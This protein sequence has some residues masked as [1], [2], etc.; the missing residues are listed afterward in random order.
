MFSR[1]SSPTPETAFTVGHAFVVLAIVA[2]G[3]VDGADLS[4]YRSVGFVEERNRI[5]FAI[6]CS[7]LSVGPA[8]RPWLMSLRD[9]MLMEKKHSPYVAVVVFHAALE[10]VRPS[11]GNCPATNRS[12]DCHERYLVLR[13]TVMTI[14][15][16]RHDH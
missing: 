3:G 9:V 8:V 16:S 4:E 11:G 13:M 6:G 15:S 2:M 10:R 1:S 12:I 7:L 5:L 14:E